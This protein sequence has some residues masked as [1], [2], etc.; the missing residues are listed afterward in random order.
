MTGCQ[1]TLLETINNASWKQKINMRNKLQIKSNFAR[2][3]V[4]RKN[5]IDKQKMRGI[6]YS[7]KN[8]FR[9]IYNFFF[10]NV[11]FIDN[12]M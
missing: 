7:K 5:Q 12:L 8:E 4:K 3:K 9:N 10:R 1:N 2:V 6:N 11:Q